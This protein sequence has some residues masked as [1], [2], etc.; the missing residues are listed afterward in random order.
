VTLL[1]NSDRKMS[2]WDLRTQKLSL[3][4]RTLI[5]GIVNITADSFSDGGRYLAP[6]LAIAHGL[7][8]LD[9]GADILDLGAESARPGAHAGDPADAAISA[10]EEQD[11][12]LPVMEGL[13]LARPD[14]VISV[15]TYKAVTAREVLRAGAEIINDVSGFT[16]D[17]EM[18][19]VCAQAQCGVI[20]MH[21]R[22]K[23]SEWGQQNRQ[24]GAELIAMVRAG[25]TES[26]R[27]ARS[28]GIA[29][30]SIVLDPGYGFG[31]RGNENYAL[32]A[33]QHELLAFGRPLLAGLSRKSFLSRT[34]SSRNGEAVP[35]PETIETAS[36]SALIAAIL[37]GASIV[38]VHS[39]RSAVAAA[40]VAD[41][42]LAAR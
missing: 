18:A 7:H 12:L 27:T 20:A 35:S 1:P 24:T 15:D 6:E 30:E 33:R 5:M 17:Q 21:T 34:V 38:R 14:A 16:W 31:K 39:V 25:L 36:M 26:L 41:A 8:L 37:Q 2:N 4:T 29:M 3:G 22:G 40:A 9:Q 28:A 11:R 32:L 13:L 19:P 10:Q 23:P 42:I